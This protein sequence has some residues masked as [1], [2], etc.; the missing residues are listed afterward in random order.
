MPATQTARPRQ[1]TAPVAADHFDGVTTR[2]EFDE[3]QLYSTFHDRSDGELLATLYDVDLGADAME[4]T[5]RLAREVCRAVNTHAE[6]LAVLRDVSAM[7][8]V[9]ARLHPADLFALQSRVVAALGKAE[10]A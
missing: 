5:N 4:Q 3:G 7:L 2:L 10:A 8:P 9:A 6:L 1:P